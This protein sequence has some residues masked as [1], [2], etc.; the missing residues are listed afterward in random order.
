MLHH[1]LYA[2]PHRTGTYSEMQIYANVFVEQISNIRQY[3]KIF[4]NRIYRVLFGE[5][6]FP[7]LTASFAYGKEMSNSQYMQS[8]TIGIY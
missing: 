7:L 5:Y 6:D 3:C 4:C 1:R 2:K 8:N